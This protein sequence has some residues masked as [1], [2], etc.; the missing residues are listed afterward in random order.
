M[1]GYAKFMKDLVTKKRLL[2]FETIKVT[3][4]VS[5]IVHSMAPKLEDPDA[6]TIPCT[7]GSAEFAKSLCDLGASINLMP[8]SVFKT[9]GI[10]KP[11]P[12]FIRFQMA[13]RIMM[14]PLGVIEDV[15]V[16]VDKFILS[17]DFVILDCEVDY[18]VPFILVRPF[19]AM[20]KTFCDV[21]ARELTFRVGDEKVK[22]P[23]TKPSIKEPP[24]LELKPLPPH[25]QYE[26]LVPCST[27]P[28]IL[29]SCL[30]NVQL[31]STLAVLHKRKKVIGWTLADIR[32]ISH[33]FCM[34]TFNLEEDA[35]PSIKHQRR[36]NDAMQEVVK[37]EI[38]KW[39]DAG[40]VYLIFNSSWTSTVQ[41]VPKKGGMKVV[42]NDKN[43]LI[44]TRTVTG[45]A[46]RAFYCFLDGYL[47]YN[48]ILISLEDQLKTTFTCPYGTFAFKRMPFGL[49]NAL[50]T[51]QRCMIVIFTY[52]VKD[53][54]EVFMD[55]FLVVRDSFD[56]CLA[57]LDKVLARCEET[58]LL[59]EKDAKFHFDDDCMRAFELLK[60]K[61]T[62]TPI[63]TAPIWGIPFELMCDASDVAVRAVLGQCINKIFHLIYYASKTMNDAQV[64]YTITEKEILAIFRQFRE[65][66]GWM[67]F[68][69]S[70]V[71]AKE[72]LV[73]EFYANVAHIKRGTKVTKVRNLNV[74]FDQHTLNTYLGFDAVEPTKYLEKCALGDPARPWLAEILADPELPSPW[75]IIGVSIHRSTLSFEAKG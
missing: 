35:K 10:G 18:E 71:D 58:N 49:C 34:H 61:L 45:L 55:D 69:Q 29:S 46:D 28:V 20:G 43:E 50:A 33:A 24:T 65:C 22:T 14:R 12:T 54:L 39:L 1:P 75:I 66:K 30:T 6:S 8:Y 27:L 9:L 25:L 2:N 56:D 53:Y 67:W 21:E 11:R 3:H 23:P 41:C 37:K 32:E 73:R 60:F 4:H 51:F 38:I 62:T 74:R 44:P 57:N 47:G 59:L 63:I 13:D 48:Q 26:F 68:T 42:I 5:A 70:V 15:L 17:A 16:R 36:L 52:M 40:V 72:Y 7:I 31:D 19:L 64:N